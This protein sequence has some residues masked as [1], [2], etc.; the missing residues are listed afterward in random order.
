MGNAD[1]MTRAD[2][3]NVLAAFDKMIEMLN[4]QWEEL[5]R[6]DLQPTK[7]G[8]E[9]EIYRDGGGLREIRIVF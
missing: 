3:A 2:I 1:R 8:G 9:Y 7:G 5:G 4:E 6:P